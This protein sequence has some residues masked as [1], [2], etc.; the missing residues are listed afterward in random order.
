LVGLIQLDDV[1]NVIF[2][3]ELYDKITIKELMTVPK[4]TIR[5]H[6]SLHD[7]L[8]K[9][10]NTNLWS[11]PVINEKKYVG[12]LSKSSILSKYRSELLKSV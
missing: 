5:L 10:D 1:R 8:A 9:F 7:V 6:E 3:Q 2:H 12:F 11:L 4:V